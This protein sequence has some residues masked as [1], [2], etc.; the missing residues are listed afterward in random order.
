MRV[1]KAISAKK[2]TRMIRAI[3]LM[4]GHIKKIAQAVAALKRRSARK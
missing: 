4:R 2:A 1:T 3:T